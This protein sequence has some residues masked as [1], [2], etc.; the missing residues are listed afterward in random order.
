MKK[1]AITKSQKRLFIVLAIVASYAV[2]DLA[3]AEP[4]Q[5]KAVNPASP[6]TPAAEAEQAPASIVSQDQQAV[7]VNFPASEWKRDPFRKQAEKWTA[8]GLDRVVETLLAPKLGNLHLTAV[9]KS[10]NKSYAIIN[11]HIV[12]VGELMNG[13][14]IV[15]INATQVI[16]KKND[17]S[18]T[19]TLP[20]DE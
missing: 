18:F 12:S 17:H 20:D 15:D 3:T 9:S 19:L 16:L 5:K 13:Y 7:H 14:K 6:N 8:F 2:F 11:D 10:G 1:T 4:K